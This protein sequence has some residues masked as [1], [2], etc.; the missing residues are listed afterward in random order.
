MDEGASVQLSHIEAAETGDV[1]LK[2]ANGAVLVEAKAY[3]ANANTK[4]RHEIAPTLAA[5][6]VKALGQGASTKALLYIV[7]PVAVAAVA[8]GAFWLARRR[9]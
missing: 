4:V 6:A 1:V 2:A 5:E 3:Q 8:A 9:S 7:A